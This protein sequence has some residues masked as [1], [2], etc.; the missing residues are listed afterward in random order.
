MTPFMPW[1]KKK[2]PWT[3]ACTATQ[4]LKQ[5]SCWFNCSCKKKKKKRPCETF[6]HCN[7]TSLL[8]SFIHTFCTRTISVHEGFDPQ[9]ASSGHCQATLHF[10]WVSRGFG[11]GLERTVSVAWF[12][13]LRLLAQTH[14]WHL[15][16]WVQ[17]RNFNSRNNLCLK[18]SSYLVHYLQ[19]VLQSTIP[20][21]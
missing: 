12:W 8:K 19:D 1:E 3:S 16:V 20:L 2:R 18:R 13:E 21:I 5:F 10:Q 9:E 7:L 14:Y 6:G 17:S 11:K 15:L 4:Q